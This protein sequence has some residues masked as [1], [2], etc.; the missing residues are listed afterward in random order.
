[1]IGYHLENIAYPSIVLNAARCYNYQKEKAS[2]A[3]AF[4]VF[5][6]IDNKNFMAWPD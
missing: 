2:L 3:E 5:K 6:I 1:L 4:N